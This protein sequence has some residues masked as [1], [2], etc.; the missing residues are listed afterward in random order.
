VHVRQWLQIQGEFD[1]NKLEV[2]SLRAEQAAEE[3][4]I[5]GIGDD[6]DKLMNVLPGLDAEA[7]AQAQEFAAELMIPDSEGVDDNEEI[8]PDMFGSDDE[9]D[10]LDDLDF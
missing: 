9:G 2:P 3:E 4:D 10:D 7:R 5:S 8:G 6:L 1:Y